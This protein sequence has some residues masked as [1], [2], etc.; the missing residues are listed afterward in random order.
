MTELHFHPLRLDDQE[1]VR[2]LLLICP[3][4][5]SELTFTNLFVWNAKRKVEVAYHGEGMLL[6]GIWE[7]KRY[8]YPPVGYSDCAST[9]ETMVQWGKSNGVSGIRGI[10]EHQ[11]RFA[12]KWPGRLWHDRD[13]DDYLYR[14]ETL[15]GLKGWR[16]DGKRGFIKKFHSNYRWEYRIFHKE[17]ESDCRKLLHDWVEAKKAENPGVIEEERAIHTLFEYYADLQVAGGVLYAEDRLAGF[18]FGEALNSSTLVVHFEKADPE[19]TGSYA[20]INQ[21]FSEHEAEGKFLYINREQDMGIAGIRKAKLSYTPVRLV[22]KI[23]MEWD[24]GTNA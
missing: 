11:K 24:G 16:L 22:K 19:F 5:V 8:F 18:T 17:F 12:K 10:P 23:N 15:S 2:Q 7:G 4:S 9:F 14:S 13:N 21:Q 20:M 1:R 6:S 3:P